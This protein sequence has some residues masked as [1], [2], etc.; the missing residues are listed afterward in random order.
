MR[1]GPFALEFDTVAL[2]RFGALPVI[3]MP[4]ALSEQDPLALLG[5]FVVGHLDQ[6]RGTLER[7]DQLAHLD[8]P[9]Y[10]Q[11]LGS[12]VVPDDFMVI[13]SNGDASRGTVQEFQIPWKVIRDLLSFIGFETAPFNAMTGVTSVAQTLFYPTDDDHHEQ[14]LG[15]YRQRE[16]RITADYYVNGL[17]RGRSL[18]DEEKDLLLEVDRYFWKGNTHTSNPNPRVDEALALVQ[19]AP[20]KLLDK[21]TRIIVPDEIYGQ[22]RQTLGGRVTAIS[23]LGHSKC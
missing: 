11:N 1:F 7:L 18:Q 16:W 20:A 21:A 12:N 19:P 8:D 23:Q 2:R 14:E 15:Y 9:A 6:I 22:A 17:P 10:V 3:Y 4:Q 13:L 5:P